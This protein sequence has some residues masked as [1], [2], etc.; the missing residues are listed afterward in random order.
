MGAESLQQVQ[1]QRD[2][3]L[4]YVEELRA[5]VEELEI[6]LE[7][8]SDLVVEQAADKGLWRDAETVGEAYLQEALRRLHA[9]IKRRAGLVSAE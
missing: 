6:A 5:R 4:A 3:L 9:V 7:D 8:A 2:R 1:K